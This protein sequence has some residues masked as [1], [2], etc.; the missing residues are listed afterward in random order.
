MLFVKVVKQI[1]ITLENVKDKLEEV[2][3]KFKKEVDKLEKE[4]L[5]EIDDKIARIRL[6]E[7]KKF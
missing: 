3:E 4:K 2:R 6:R 5:I 7:V 1:E